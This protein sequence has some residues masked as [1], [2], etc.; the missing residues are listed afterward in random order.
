MHAGPVLEEPNWRAVAPHG[1][2]TTPVVEHLDVLEAIGLCIDSRR[3]GRAMHPLV[4][5]AVEEVERSALQD[6]YNPHEPWPCGVTADG[7]VLQ[8]Q[9]A[10]VAMLIEVLFDLLHG[11]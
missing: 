2:A 7:E 3:V 10:F 8:E 4:I 11:S 5:Q 9:A 1:V 6:H